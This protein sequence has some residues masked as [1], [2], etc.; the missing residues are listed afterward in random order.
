MQTV[1]AAQK[2]VT[3]SSVVP[4]Y[5]DNR[6]GHVAVKPVCARTI[7]RAGIRC[8]EL[9]KSAAL[10]AIEAVVRNVRVP[11]ESDGLRI[12]NYAIH[13]G[14]CRTSPRPIERLDFPARPAQESFLD[15]R[16]GVRVVP[17]HDPFAVHPRNDRLAVAPVG[18]ERR[19]RSAGCAHKAVPVVAA[20]DVKTACS[21]QGIDSDCKRALP[22]AG[23]GARNIEDRVIRRRPA[24]LRREMPLL[25]TCPARAGISWY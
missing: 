14:A 16:I 6:A 1:G 17:D 15:T 13:E 22:E 19:E 9:H 21:G 4:N 12:I 23:P 2:C 25:R 7:L 10:C 24:V 18:V 5:T 20:V 8:I 11:V 3:R